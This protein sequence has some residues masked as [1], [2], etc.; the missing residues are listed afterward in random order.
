MKTI[1]DI[2]ELYKPKSADEDRFVKKHVIKKTEDANGNKDDVF[3]ATNV[4]P[5]ERTPKH[6]YNPGED[7]QVYE[8]YEEIRFDDPENNSKPS[9]STRDSRSRSERI[10]AEMNKLG[11][12]YGRKNLASKIKKKYSTKNEETVSEDTHTDHFRFLLPLQKAG[13]PAPSKERAMDLIAKHGDPLRAGQ[14]YVDRYKKIKN[15]A[16]KV[17]KEET[18]LDEASTGKP[19]S[20]LYVGTVSRS[21]PDYNQKIGELKSRT[22]G[23]H[24]IRGRAPTSEYKHLYAVGGKLHRYSSQDIKPEH[25]SHVDV[26]SRNPMKEEVEPLDEARRKLSPIEK[27]F[28]RPSMQFAKKYTNKKSADEIKM[29]RL[30]FPA[31]H[32]PKDGTDTGTTSSLEGKAKQGKIEDVAKRT[33]QNNSYEPE[34]EE[35]DEARTKKS[36]TEVKPVNP[37]DLLVPLASVSTKPPRGHKQYNPRSD[38]PGVKVLKNSYEPEGDQ[39]NELVLNPFLR[40]LLEATCKE[41][42]KTYKK[43]GSCSCCMKEDSQIDEVLTPSKRRQMA[44][45][46]HYAAKRGK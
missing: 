19:R 37:K 38:F 11:N 32:L 4:K 33:M 17:Q 39:F 1:K 35:L 16:N 12:Q 8:G 20:S 30:G 22:V 9:G 26:Y 29:E 7:E 6:G 15:A 40:G 43:G 28:N 2:I 23:G 45:A 10:D 31:R 36:S 41:C 3:N 24:R 46:A 21:D 44:L 25:S 42:G 5:T 18:E 34:G 13:V 27:L 14:A